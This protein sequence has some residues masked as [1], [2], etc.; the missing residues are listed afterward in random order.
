[1]PVLL[2]YKEILLRLCWVSRPVFTKTMIF[3]L[4]HS[5]ERSAKR[6]PKKEAFKCLNKSITYQELD[7]KTNQLALYLI[8]VG[9]SK[10]DR[11]GIYLNRCLESAIAV[12]GILKAGA[13][14]VPLNPGAPP[15]H[16]SFVID[17]CGIEHIVTGALQRKGM[18][19]VLEV[20]PGLKTVAGMV[21]D[22]SLP[23]TGWEKIFELAGKP[24][25]SEPVLESDL[26]YILYTSG[27]TGTPKGIMHTHHSGLSY[28]RLSVA[29]Y[30]LNE[31]DRFA[32]HSPLHFDISTLGYFAAPYLGA[33]TVILSDAHTKMPASQA[34]VIEKEK[35]TIWYSV[36]LAL[37]QMLQAGV[38]N[39]LDASSLRW[40]FFAG[41]PFTTKHLRSLM[42]IWTHSE[43]SNLYGPTETNVCTHYQLP[44][45]P[46]TDEPISIGRVWANTQSLVLD[47]N[48]CEVNP[49]DVGELVIRSPTMM[50]GYWKKP[51][52][53]QKCF[54]KRKNAAGVEETYYRT[55][56]SVKI[57]KAGDF[58]FIGRRDRQV[59]VRGYR[60]ELDQISNVLLLHEAVEEAAVF[61]LQGKLQEVSIH[62]QVLLKEGT[63]LAETELE[64][65]VQE[66]LPSY[67]IPET[68]KVVERL[69]RT[70][71]GKINHLKLEGRC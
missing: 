50:Y 14:Y 53:N 15:A 52:L 27:S 17:D 47:E 24:Q 59:K 7:E 45:P 36:P 5:I 3:L 43:F 1:M 40:V 64:Q 39:N 57:N 60:I 70:P 61:T 42:Q 56:D 48:D 35:I 20:T 34:Q 46:E 33:T 29:S 6:F 10:G 31:N 22:W 21:A 26:A 18:E 16:T 2:T 62:A 66:K 58:V 8:K 13:A 54:F 63:V 32:N 11:V 30:D 23:T 38:L 69:P 65:I 51:E 41:E 12:Y 71:T 25:L 68:I 55:G 44:A 37:L 49:G 28:A 4:N 19:A 9:V 67:A